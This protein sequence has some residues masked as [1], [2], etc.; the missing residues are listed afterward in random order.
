M[1]LSTLSL[2]LNKWMDDLL[3]QHDTKFI[4]GWNTIEVMI[5][6]DVPLRKTYN[7]SPLSAEKINSF[8]PLI[9]AVQIRVPSGFTAMN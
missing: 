9:D 4:V 1:H 8:V 2:V 5:A 3:E 7:F 6:F